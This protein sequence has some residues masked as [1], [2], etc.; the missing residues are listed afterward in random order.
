MIRVMDRLLLSVEA[1]SGRVPM[2]VLID[3]DLSQEVAAMSTSQTNAELS[4]RQ[5]CTGF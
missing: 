4:Q 5:L 1:T 3:E 2:T